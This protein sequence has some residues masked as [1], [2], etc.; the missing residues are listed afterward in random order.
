MSIP[1]SI[2]ENVEIKG[3]SRLRTHQRQRPRIAARCPVDWGG[4]RWCES[5]SSRSHQP[6]TAAPLSSWWRAIETGG[7]SQ[8]RGERTSARKRERWKYRGRESES[9][10]EKRD[11]CLKGVKN[12]T[13][14]RMIVRMV[15][16]PKYKYMKYKFKYTHSQRQT[17][18]TRKR[19]K[20]R[21]WRKTPGIR[22][23]RYTV[24]NIKLYI[25]K[26]IY[27]YTTRIYIKYIIMRY[28]RYKNFSNK[29]WNDEFNKKLINKQKHS[30]ILV[31][32]NFLISFF[33]E[34]TKLS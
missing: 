7:R 21:K 3:Q 22:I 14:I 8:G 15:R 11:A 29:I 2:A 23:M 5:R 30:F 4:C 19:R 26:Y 33:L 28:I 31:F 34:K 9:E 10:S 13:E 6:C 16:C 17:S 27:I 32:L 25:I 20:M 18:K 12:I 24:Y 1:L